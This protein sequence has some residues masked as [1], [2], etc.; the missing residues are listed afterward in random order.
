M[1]SIYKTLRHKKNSS[2]A[3]VRTVHYKTALCRALSPTQW[4]ATA[5]RVPEGAGITR[6]GLL[7]RFDWWATRPDM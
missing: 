4:L 6:K 7:L 3:P 1:Y 5:M 2:A